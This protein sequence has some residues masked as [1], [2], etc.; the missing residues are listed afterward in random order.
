[1]DLSDDLLKNI[2]QSDDPGSLAV[3]IQYDR[4]I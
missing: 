1:M 3:F 4:D 2:F